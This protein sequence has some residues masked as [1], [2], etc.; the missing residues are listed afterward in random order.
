MKIL[1]VRHGDPDYSIDSLTPKGWREARFLAQRLVQTP[2]AAY[3]CSPM[4]RAQDTASFTL[5]GLGRSAQTCPWLREFLGF[6]VRPDRGEKYICWDWLP[7]DWTQ[8]ERFYRRDAWLEPPVMAE[9]NVREEYAWVTGE[10]DKLLESH[11]YRREGSFY[12]AVRGN[13]DTIVFFCHFGVECVLLS[14]LL[15][16]SPMLLWHG[17]MAAPTSVTTVATEERREGIAYFRMSSFGDVSHL[18]AN[19]EA[20]AFAGRFCECWG[21]EGERID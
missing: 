3:Y 14:H 17:T 20:P 6:I 2:A 21:N 19:G 4:G 1:I 15:N 16:I 5:Q 18:Y 13:N 8:E 9:G 11:G 7:Q 10:L 12:R